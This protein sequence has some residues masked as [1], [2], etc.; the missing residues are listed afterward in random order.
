MKVKSRRATVLK[1]PWLLPSFPFLSINLTIL[2]IHRAQ[3]MHVQGHVHV[4][5]R[6]RACGCACGVRGEVREGEKEREGG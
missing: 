5:A 6:V 2:N 3:G 4:R 1:S